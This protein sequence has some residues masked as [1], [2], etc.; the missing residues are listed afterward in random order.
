MLR[1]WAS[2]ATAVPNAS[3]YD[4]DFIDLGPLKGNVGNQNYAIPE[5]VDLKRHRTA[6][7]W[8]RRFE[9]GFA[10]AVLEPA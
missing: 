5:S 3:R 4:A 6:V 10:A 1:P 9:V 7:V 8:C 2:S